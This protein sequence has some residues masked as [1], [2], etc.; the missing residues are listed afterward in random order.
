MNRKAK[1]LI[2]DDE[3]ILAVSMERELARRGYQTCES[4]C[5]GAEALE[6]LKTEQ[7]DLVVLD[8][9]LSGCDIDGFET[10]HRIRSISDVPI[11]FMSGLSRSEIE[12]K[13]NAIEGSAFLP[14]PFNPEAMIQVI[15]NALKTVSPPS[16]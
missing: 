4:A 1:I 15:E 9:C 8:C 14:K 2:V 6:K 16:S 10:A 5:S 12:C 7:P 13:T 11:V 3:V